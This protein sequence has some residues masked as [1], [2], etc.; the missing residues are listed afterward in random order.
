MDGLIGEIRVFA[1]G[2]NPPEWIPCD[3]RQLLIQQ[4][5]PLYSIVGTKYGGTSSTFNVPDLRSYAVIGA[6]QGP[7]LTDRP[8]A[9]AIGEQSVM[10]S[11]SNM[12][13]HNHSVN[14]YTGLPEDSDYSNA[15]VP[16]SSFLG[17]MF[18]EDG[19]GNRT[20]LNGYGNS[21][22]NPVQLKSDSVSVAGAPTVTA[23]ENRS[24]FTALNYCICWDGL[25]PQRPE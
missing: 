25:Y 12:P 24:P 19:A 16:G 23:H 7:G 14:V 9:V 3:G 6:G 21:Q 20:E 10:L 17:N 5:T 22:L 4:Y 13:S 1:F 8:D 2:Y 15:P 18:V 11:N